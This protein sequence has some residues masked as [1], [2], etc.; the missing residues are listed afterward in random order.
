MSKV[1]N[2]GG[3]DYTF[4]DGVSDE[5]ALQRIK[6][7]LAK[8]PAE[9]EP[10]N[11]APKGTYQNPEYEGFLTEMGE[12]VLSGALGIF[13][14][15]G[16]LGGIA[17]DAAGATDNAAKNVE[18]FFNDT[19]RNKGGKMIFG[20]AIDPAGMTGKLT[21]GI[22][23]FGVPGV[24]VAGLIGKGTLTVGKN[25][26]KA[27]KLVKDGEKLT[28]AQRTNLAVQQIV[29]AGIADAIVS[30]DNTESV[31]D[32][33]EEGPF[34][35][36]KRLGTQGREDAYRRFMNKISIG[37]EGAIATTVLPTAIKG[38]LKGSTALASARIPLGGDRST[39]IAQAAAFIPKKGIIDPISK[40]LTG[41]IERFRVDESTG[42]LDAVVGKVASTLTYQG[43]LDPITAKMRSLISPAIEGD[44]KIAERKLRNIDES[45]EKELKTQEL[46]ELS[47]NQKVRLMNNFMDVLEGAEFS[48]FNRGV[49][50]SDILSR[51]LFNKFKEAKTVIDDL[52]QRM[53][54]TG[55]FKNLPDIVTAAGRKKGM[56]SKEDFRAAIDDQL[57]SGGYLQ[58]KY[59]VFSNKNYEMTPAVKNAL[60]KQIKGK[61]K[62][63]GQTEGST[64][65]IEHMQKTLNK[66]PGLSD[67]IRISKKNVEEFKNNTY[68]IT[69]RQADLYMD[70]VLSLAKKR[71]G[72][73]RSPSTTRYIID[74]LNPSLINKQ[75]VDDK[76]I[77]Q[78]YGQIRDPREAYVSTVSELS[79]F[80]STDAYYMSFKNMA[81]KA[82]VETAERN[83]KIKEKN[84]E[85]RQRN[86][87]ARANGVPEDKLEQEIKY[88]VDSFI[89]T[90]QILEDFA[91]RKK[92][93]VGELTSAETAQ[94]LERIRKRA[95]NL[96][97]LGRTDSSDFS[98]GA[99]NT[100]PYGAM[101]GYAVPKALYKSLSTEVHS[102][103][104]IQEIGR[105]LYAPFL[106]MKGASQYAKTILSPYTQVRN[107][108]SAAM[109]ALAQGNLGKGANVFE[110]ADIV[111]RDIIDK[112]RSVKTAGLDFKQDEESLAFLAKLQK[113]GVIGSSA[114]LREL[115]D[116]IKKGLGYRKT[117]TDI[118]R[119]AETPE[120][121]ATYIKRSKDIP[122]V[123]K[124]LQFS[125]DLYRGGDDIWKIY[126]Y[127]FE[128]NKLRQA[129][130]KII[131][132]ETDKRIQNLGTQN[133]ENLTPDQQAKFILDSKTVANRRFLQSM[134]GSTEGIENADKLGKAIDDLL[135]NTASD[136]VRNLVPNYD[137]T[138]EVIRGLRKLP[139]G[140]FISFPAE[141][142]R[143]GFN[144]INTALK[145]MS[146]NEAAIR[147]IG[148]RRL[149][150]AST[151]FYLVGDQVQKFGQYMTGTNDEE[152]K[153]AQ[154]LSAPYQRNSQFVPVGRD[155][156][157]NLE[158]VDF[159]HTNPYDLLL[160][161]I[162]AA[163]TGIDTSGKLKE[164]VSD[165]VVRSMWESMTEFFNP[166]LDESMIFSAVADVMPVNA[167]LIGR[168]GET[169]SGAK[170]YSEEDSKL[171][172][173]E[174][175]M[176]HI[177][178]TFNPGILP[179]RV[180]VGAELGLTNTY[181]RGKLTPPVKGIEAGR[182]TRGLGFGA[183]KEPTTG[184]E[185]TA[186][187]ELFRAFTGIGT[188]TI[189]RERI[190]NFK[191]QEF[192]ES[193]SKA[194][195]IFNQ[196]V[197]QERPTVNQIM[198][199]YRQ[200][201]DS[202]LT[203][204]KEM[205][206]NI[207]DLK[208]LGATDRMIRKV[209]KDA[210][211]GVK[212]RSALLRDRYIPFRPSKE[213]LIE[214]R[215]K[216]IN[217]PISLINREY[218]LRNNI[219]LSAKRES[220]DQEAVGMTKPINLDDVE[221]FNVKDDSE[222]TRGS[223]SPLL[224]PFMATRPTT[225][226]NR[227]NAP[228]LDV[229]KPKAPVSPAI[230]GDNPEDVLK[231]M[232]IARNR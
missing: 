106:K 197:R 69:E 108:T 149:M 145:E 214:L 87:E 79:S 23:Q 107:V 7:H 221:R 159:S 147:E 173:F 59:E 206:L 134:G 101:F 148:V 201:D 120:Q 3:V 200:A 184:R 190:L 125:E 38:F 96:H 133:F 15:V 222:Q 180:P 194:A 98:K 70:K 193:R 71:A 131:K 109:F 146:S 213:K 83:A 66:I 191:A 195:S 155:K 5:E 40:G 36:D 43:L 209:L 211:L 207:E 137:L 56:M 26:R 225:T 182:L 217:V 205:R 163:I 49:D 139:L 9:P 46:R 50:G 198:E 13:Q 230:L 97:V 113:Q 28:K 11:T 202:R 31:S 16:E 196:I 189:D 177:M 78:I 188:Q 208:K 158:F 80:L 127:S 199:A 224:A 42:T 67:Q 85:I 165:T 174:K 68:Q 204:F 105:A 141:I 52:S 129:Q 210:A 75:K 124:F 116:N 57:K 110:S 60:R 29:G 121:G 47:G 169:R 156:K 45:I 8:Q 77:Q 167:P 64:V 65:D 73:D 61:I 32:F 89:N 100:S 162:R 171:R 170:I 118:E 93:S 17:L 119:A 152:I 95:E 187:G 144:T 74:R 6:T 122:Y 62:K 84:L 72:F 160:R 115:L 19:I 220:I 48:N 161:P 168:N 22:V 37:A 216:K 81:D 90:N 142:M 94:A 54:D 76:I 18:D 86:N 34:Q 219:K 136:N 21:E 203:T 223:V 178:N 151:A 164:G 140:N 27:A 181:E 132:S 39:S 212:E 150:G 25:M 91:A 12:G 172:Q 111:L 229:F 99:M 58:R 88:E 112:G 130:R 82:I 24:G 179:I 218:R 117:A 102:S 44:V 103:S 186:T 33:F 10:V 63:P 51:D 104:S 123:G 92:K 35:T 227:I 30:T 153:A 55:A 185:Y 4:E 41:S 215:K 157:G 135:E 192:K 128:K 175:S 232:Q 53:E 114:N 2:Y 126:N 143:T 20:S 1:F 183:K 226:N 138:P 176:V 154:R 166:F 231:N 14:G 228:I